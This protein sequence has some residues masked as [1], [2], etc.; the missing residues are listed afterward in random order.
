[1]CCF[2]RFFKFSRFSHCALLYI[3][4]SLL[5]APLSLHILSP[6]RFSLQIM[7]SLCVLFLP[8]S[9]F[10][11]F[12][13]PLLLCLCFELVDFSCLLT[14]S[15][16]LLSPHFVSYTICL[17]QYVLFSSSVLTP[18]SFIHLISPCANICDRNVSLPLHFFEFTIILHSSYL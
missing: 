5:F 9:V 14:L 2:L 16:T 1:M 4:C 10:S 17:L 8:F 6:P 7:Y 15:V 13:Q 3:H 11:V 12:A 18:H